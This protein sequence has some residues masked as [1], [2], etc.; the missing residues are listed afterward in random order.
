MSTSTEHP[1]VFISYSWTNPE[2]EQFV[3]DLATTLLGHGIDAVLDKWDLK[4]GHDKYVFMESMVVDPSVQKVL[5]ICD[6]K[7]QEKANA[8]AGGVG[9]ESQIISQELYGRV[10]QTKFVPVVCEYDDDG[11]PCLPVFMKGLI[12][13]DLSS[14]ERY[15]AGLDE[16]LRLI[17]AQ[18]FHQKPKLGGIPSF[19]SSSGAS[20]VK[21]LGAALRAIQDGKPNRQG[22]EALFIKSLLGEVTRLYVTPEGADYDEGVFQAISSTKVLRDQLAEYVDVVAAFSGDDT[23]SLV[24]FLRLMEG[25]GGHFGPPT[26]QGSFYPGWADLYYFFAHEAFL[27]QTAALLRHNRWRC[28]RRLTSAIYVIQN[29]RQSD[30]VAE[31]YV[32]FDKGMVSLDEHRNKRL[33]LNRVSVVADMLKERCSTDKTSFPELLEADVFLMLGSFV[34]SFSPTPPTDWPRIWLAHTTVYASYGNRLKVFLRAADEDIRTGIR[35]A[36]GVTSGS[37]LQTR[38]E[39]AQKRFPDFNRN[40]RHHDQFEFLDAINFSELVK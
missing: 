36:I 6:Q 37:D 8:R 4:P 16:L 15:G 17:Y 35:T 3:V 26:D 34:S 20:Y 38:L 2:H 33:N 24:P 10:T 22:L 23:N 5:V 32:A 18:P 9:T 27:I 7:Y 40:R 12:Y 31:T 19:V 29:S 1:K 11:L 39:A 21:E 14:D 30:T 28:L 25:L 13:I